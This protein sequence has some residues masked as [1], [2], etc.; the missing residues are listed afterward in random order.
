MYHCR[1]TY[2]LYVCNKSPDI[3]NKFLNLFCDTCLYKGLTYCSKL[4]NGWNNTIQVHNDYSFWHA[5]CFEEFLWRGEDARILTFWT[6]LRK[7]FGQVTTWFRQEQF[8]NHL[9]RNM[10]YLH[11]K[12]F[13]CFSPP[14]WPSWKPSISRNLDPNKVT[15]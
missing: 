15:R 11:A 14:T 8:G 5:V 4:I 13:H 10:I 9:P 7:M 6:S 3:R 1:P 12:L 2:N